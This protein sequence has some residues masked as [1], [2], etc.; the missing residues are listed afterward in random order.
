M[1]ITAELLQAAVISIAE[2]Y[3]LVVTMPTAQ[4]AAAERAEP[5]ARLERMAAVAVQEL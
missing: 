5:V 3:V 1:V 4:V 2:Q